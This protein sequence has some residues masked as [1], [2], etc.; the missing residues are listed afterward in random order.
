MRT[1]LVSPR[2]GQTQA[3]QRL[4]P[5]QAAVAAMVA[6]GKARG[7]VLTGPYSESKLFTKT[8]LEGQFSATLVVPPSRAHS[9]RPS[10]RAS[11]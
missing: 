7:L 2:E 4:S 6:D 10:G 1:H 3:G 11:T 9:R 8:V 5:E